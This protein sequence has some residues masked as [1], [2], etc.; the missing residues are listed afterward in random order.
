[1]SG[2]IRA[3]VSVD[4][5]TG[6]PTTEVVART[7]ASTDDVTRAV[8]ADGD[9]VVEEFLLADPVGVELDGFETTFEPVFDYGDHV[10]YR[11]E[12]ARDVACPC[13][14]VDDHGC[15]VVDISVRAD[16]LHIAFHANDMPTLQSVV[17][18]LR[19]RYP[20]LDVRRLLRSEGDASG[21]NLVFVDRNR[22]TDRQLEVLE[23]AHEMGY[24]AH[25]KG[26]NAGQVADALDVTRSTF[27][28]HLAAA[29]SKLLDAV[30]D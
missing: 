19:E 13:E 29:Q 24:F 15:P 26:A 17:G 18:D 12:R 28:E 21:H 10:T 22:L 4:A 25:P 20:S 30:L 2:G 27:T 9:R 1:M 23:T 14:T 16:E 3:E 6:C 7:G 5:P 8:S 11:F